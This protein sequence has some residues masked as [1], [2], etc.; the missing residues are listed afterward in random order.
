VAPVV[1]LTELQSVVGKYVEQHNMIVA[2][3][4]F[5]AA[6]LTRVFITKNKLVSGAMVAGGTWLAAQELSGPMLRLMQEQFGYLQ[7]LFGGF[8]G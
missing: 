4:P 2:A 5:T 3:G 8:R 7:A 6:A 1:D